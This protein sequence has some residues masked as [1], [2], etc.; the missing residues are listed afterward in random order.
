M[1]SM[2]ILSTSTARL[3]SPTFAPPLAV[4]ST[5]PTLMGTKLATPSKT[6]ADAVLYRVAIPIMAALGSFVFLAALA[7]TFIFRWSRTK[8]SLSPEA[9]PQ[10]CVSDSPRILTT[11][12]L[13]PDLQRHSVDRDSEIQ[14]VRPST[15]EYARGPDTADGLASTDDGRS[16]GEMPFSL[17]EDEMP[18]QYAVERDRPAVVL[19]EHWQRRG[20][21]IARDGGV[22]LDQGPGAEEMRRQISV[23]SVRTE[24]SVGTVP[25]TSA[26]TLPPLYGQY[27]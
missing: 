4:S 8:S 2:L 23:R 16:D 22:L 7:I 12:P 17:V 14:P 27:N 25:S 11:V 20:R 15:A 18:P 13:P 24:F 9:S 21:R 3:V 19:E 5:T 26:S 1:N 10:S 6:S